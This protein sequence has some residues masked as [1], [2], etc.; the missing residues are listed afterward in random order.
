MPQ[1]GPDGSH[2]TTHGPTRLI[3]SSFR[4][5]RYESTEQIIDPCY[6]ALQ[7]LA[8]TKVI[9]SGFRDYKHALETPRG[10]RYSLFRNIALEEMVF[11]CQKG[12]IL[13]LTYDCPRSLSK[14]KIQ[15]SGIFEDGML[16]ALIGIDKQTNQAH[17]TFL[18]SNLSGSTVSES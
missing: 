11:H 4:L 6:H 13:R 1:T 16:C 5:L 14:G 7:E 9:E 2:I 8:H 10:I 18:E 15:S 12:A 17:V 3:D